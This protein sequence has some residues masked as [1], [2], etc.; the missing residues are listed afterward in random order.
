MRVKL[1]YLA[2][3]REALGTSGEEVDL[4]REIRDVAALTDW[5]RSRG[6]TFERELSAQSKIRIAVDHKIAEGHTPIREG[7]EVAFFP[8]V[9]GG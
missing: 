7:A 6:A 3:L 5:L 9:T 4:P 2:R 1:V 8:P